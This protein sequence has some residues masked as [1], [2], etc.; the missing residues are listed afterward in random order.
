MMEAYLPTA[1]IERL[2]LTLWLHVD[3]CYLFVP[4]CTQ[5]FYHI[6]SLP[7]GV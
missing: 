1:H 2:L 6:Y 3:C 7:V 5:Y 4:T